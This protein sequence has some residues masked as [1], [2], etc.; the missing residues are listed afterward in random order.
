MHSSTALSTASGRSI[1]NVFSLPVQ[2]LVYKQGFKRIQ[3]NYQCTEKQWKQF[4]M[5]SN[6]LRKRTHLR[7][8]YGLMV[9]SY[10]V[11]KERAETNGFRPSEAIYE[12][13]VIIFFHQTPLLSKSPSRYHLCVKIMFSHL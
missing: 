8:C 11:T 3:G 5:Y 1:C 13:Y 7:P 6:H 9:R 12:N 4:V 2:L 10:C